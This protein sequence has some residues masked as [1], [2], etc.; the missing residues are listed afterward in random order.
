MGKVS[1][2][3]PE[4]REVKVFNTKTKEERTL[5]E[6]LSKFSDWERAVKAIACL[7]RH[8]K[9]RK[10]FK[11]KTSETTSMEERQ[12]AELFIIKLVQKEAFSCEIKRL[13]QCKEVRPKR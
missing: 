10:G 7:K 13:K 5:L 4:L 6:C 12:E 3:D 11:S 2:Y 8:V 9:Q 1:D